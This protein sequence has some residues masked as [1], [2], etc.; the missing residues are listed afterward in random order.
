MYLQQVMGWHYCLLS[1]TKIGWKD[2][3][4]AKKPYASHGHIQDLK[5]SQEISKIEQELNSKE[6]NLFHGIPQTETKEVHL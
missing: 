1:L 2:S 6:Y 4:K 3:R 5:K